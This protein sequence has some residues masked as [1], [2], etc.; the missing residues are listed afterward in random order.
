MLLKPE[1]TNYDPTIGLMQ[2][3][4]LWPQRK[5][6]WLRQ[7]ARIK[8]TRPTIM[9]PV[10]KNAPY[11]LW[12]KAA[13]DQVLQQALKDLDRSFCNILAH[14]ADFPAFRKKRKD[15]TCLSVPDSLKV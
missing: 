6:V 4:R 15:K 11:M 1:K 5:S 7:R 14:R 2:P 12:L 3:T 9:L 8:Y 10:R 13:P